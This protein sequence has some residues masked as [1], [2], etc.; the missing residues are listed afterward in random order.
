M[1][2][3]KGI[4]Q[5]YKYGILGEDLASNYLENIGYK[6]LERN[7]LCKQGEIDIIAKDNDEYVFIEVK[8]RSNCCFGRPSEAVNDFKKKHILKS[9]KYYLYLHN[10]EEKFIRFD[11]IEVYLFNH[12]YKINHLKQVDIV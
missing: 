10:L 8:T 12:K 7:F 3:N 5:F 1:N 9:T 4:T 2:E 11:V 6:I